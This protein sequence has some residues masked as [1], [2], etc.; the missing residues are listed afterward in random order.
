M[1]MWSEGMEAERE[2]LTT[3]LV[4]TCVEVCGRLRGEGH[5]SDFIDP[6][7]GTPHYSQHSSTTLSETDERLR[8][9]GLRIEDLGCCKVLSHPRFGRNV[10]VGLVVTNAAPGSD[11]L[12][13]IVADLQ[14]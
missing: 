5:F 11:V 2:A 9:V 6:C 1:S 14:Q 10:L 7:S 13:N 8:L 12:Q 3:D 4:T